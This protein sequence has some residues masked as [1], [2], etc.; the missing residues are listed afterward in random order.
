MD[1]SISKKLYRGEGN[2][3]F[4]RERLA[5]KAMNVGIWEHSL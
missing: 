3:I 4:G 1:I 5:L 2:E